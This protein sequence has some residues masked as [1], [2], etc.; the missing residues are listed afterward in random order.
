[1]QVAGMF[2]MNVQVPWQD[3]E[4]VWPWFGILIGMVIASV[5]ALFFIKKLKML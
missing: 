3:V 1:M 4:N 2:G 5:L